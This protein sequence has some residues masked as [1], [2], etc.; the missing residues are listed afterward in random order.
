[1]KQAVSNVR[2]SS[3]VRQTKSCGDLPNLVNL[4]DDN[5]Y[6]EYEDKEDG[7]NNNYSSSS[8]NDADVSHLVTK[9]RMALST[10][11]WDSYGIILLAPNVFLIRLIWT[12][13]DES[14]QDEYFMATN[15]LSSNSSEMYF[16]DAVSEEK[17][18]LL[19]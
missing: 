10:C 3:A 13:Q 5:S 19:K 4:E 8:S 11:S 1:M 16:S 12:S 17:V 9:R 6:G 18:D 15:E 7:T 2:R 14:S